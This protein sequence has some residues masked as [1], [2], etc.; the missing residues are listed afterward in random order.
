MYFKPPTALKTQINYLLARNLQITDANSKFQ[1]ITSRLF[2]LKMHPFVN[3]TYGKAR[4]QTGKA[5][6]L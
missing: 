6:A 1:A 5:S 4:N 2:C 3:H